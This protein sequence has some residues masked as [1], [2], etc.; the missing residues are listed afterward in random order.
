MPPARKRTSKATERPDVSVVIASVNGLPYPLACLEGLSRQDGGVRSEILLADC[1]GPATVA[2]VRERFPEV[3]V[4]TFDSPR[5]VPA[6][7]SAGMDAARGR[8]VAVTEDHCVPRPDWLRNIVDAQARTGWAAVGGGVVNGSVERA[9]DWAVFFCEYSG[10]MSPVAAGP[11]DGLPGMNVAYDMDALNG[12]RDAFREA[13]WE[14]FVHER[15]RRAGHTLGLDPSIVV[16]HRKN[17]T[18][19]GF[20]SERFHYSRSYAG[21]RV[22]GSGRAKRLAWAAG[23]L[24]LPP[25]LVARVSANVLRRRE[26]TRALARAF[27][28]VVLFSVAWA[29]GELVG[30]LTG[31]GDSLV[32]VR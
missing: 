19:R 4:I 14:S 9:V 7:R 6:L 5:S 18:V 10:L 26:H 22:E 24:L 31:P 28:L 12:E 25:L 3:K 2:A 20:L 30:Y 23:S 17:F 1:T 32:K 29:L 27:P 8:I 13:R 21:M 11:A 15:L 16:E